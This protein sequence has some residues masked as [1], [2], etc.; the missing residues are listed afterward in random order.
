MSIHSLRESP[1]QVTYVVCSAAG[2]AWT[3]DRHEH[4]RRSHGILKDE[5]IRKQQ[6]QRG[7]EKKRLAFL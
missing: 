7:K 2:H 3:L 5:K 1:S 6:Q 4:E